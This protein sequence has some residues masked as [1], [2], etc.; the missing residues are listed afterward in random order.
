MCCSI[1]GSPTN[2]REKEGNAW[3][4]R[5]REREGRERGE[6]EERKRPTGHELGE[7]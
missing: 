5:K 6:K 3:K 2:T 4:R 1:I 7:K